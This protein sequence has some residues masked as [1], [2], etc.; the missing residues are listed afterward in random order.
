MSTQSQIGSLTLIEG[1]R[2][3]RPIWLEI[4]LK[5]NRRWTYCFRLS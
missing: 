1:Y 3:R 2:Y 5:K 4:L